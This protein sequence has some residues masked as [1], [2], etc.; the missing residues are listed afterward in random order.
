MRNLVLLGVAILLIA[1]MIF[2]YFSASQRK[3][4]MVRE[5]LSKLEQ[6]VATKDRAQVAAALSELITDDGSITLKVHFFSIT[7]NNRPMLEQ[8]FDK[9]QFLNFIDNTLYSLTDYSYTARLE[10]LDEET[11]HVMFNSIE[12]ADGANMMGGVSL[13]MRYSSDTSCE[14]QV[15]FENDT[16]RLKQ[17]ICTL[18]FRQSPKPG[19]EGKFLEK[20][21]LQELLGA[22]P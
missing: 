10:S 12:W 11:G 2:Y 4:R 16:A 8:T 13:N 15:V 21:N 5:A 7:A 3:E 9:G 20:K 22:P 1:A 17:A 19:Q 14:G 18:Q 6:A